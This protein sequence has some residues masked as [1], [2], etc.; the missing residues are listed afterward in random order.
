MKNLLSTLI[1]LWATVPSFAQVQNNQISILYRITQ[2][3][4]V[5]VD[6]SDNEWTMTFQHQLDGV[7][8]G[9][10]ATALM[11]G[12]VGNST[13][14]AGLN[15]VEENVPYGDIFGLFVRGWE[16]DSFSDEDRYTYDDGD[17]MY[18]QGTA[19]ING[20]CVPCAGPPAEWN[21][22]PAN[23]GGSGWVGSTLVPQSSLWDFK[24]QI[25]W[26]YMNGDN[27][28]QPLLLGDLVAAGERFDVNSN[29]QL[30]SPSGGLTNYSNQYSGSPSADVY[31][32]FSLSD[33]REVTLSTDHAETVFDTHLFLL[34]ADGN[35]LADN[36]D[37]ASGNLQSTIV[38]Q[39]C[40]GQYYVVVEGFDAVSEGVFRLT[41]E[42]GGFLA[43]FED[44]TLD[45]SNA[46]CD[47]S[48]DGFAVATPDGGIPP[49]NYFWYDVISQTTLDNGDNLY[50]GDF[51]VQVIDACG[52]EVSKNFS[53]EA[54]DTVF[55]EA[56]CPPFTVDV[57]NLPGEVY[58]LD[59]ATIVSFSSDNCGAVF[60]T[61]FAPMEYGSDDAPDFT[62]SITV[63]DQ[64]GNLS[65]C[66]GTVQVNVIT[67]VDQDETL[68]AAVDVFPNPT[69]DVFT[70]RAQEVELEGGQ[71]FLRDMNGRLV[72]RRDCPDARSWQQ[73]FDISHL[74]TGIYT[75][76]IRSGQHQLT[77]RIIR[78]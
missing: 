48:A 36:D 60:V 29:N 41:A 17:D 16:D 47:G 52:S 28:N 1:L 72:Y 33:A 75:L 69:T 65:S 55:P 24:Y 9:V 66:L 54:E 62:Y 7:G 25:I 22:D 78:Q 37:V 56:V 31:Y 44:I 12:D 32:S 4:T 13:S 43:P 64:A 11:D 53:I 35:L 40:P 59:T 68:A 76:Q 3:Y 34:D 45:L 42:A 30:D 8:N 2:T 51:L 63:S 26:R 38:E 23:V 70:I 58:L 14:L 19:I 5:A 6:E 18:Y 71:L 74:A 67:S 39:L 20:G 27:F 61:D 46:S 57:P 77:R 50:P 49:Y 21:T 73:V 10:D 15:I